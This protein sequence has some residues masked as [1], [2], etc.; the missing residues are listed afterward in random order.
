MSGINK[1]FGFQTGGPGGGDTNTNVA[2]ADLTLDDNHTTD[3][4][5][6]T[7]TIDSGTTN[8]AQFVGSDNT[9][10]IGGSTPYKMPTARAGKAGHAIQSTDAT[11]GTAFK[12]NGFALPF[13]MYAQGV[14]NLNYWYPEPMSNNKY[15]HLCRDSGL[16]DPGDWN[17]LTSTTLRACISGIPNDASV[18]SINAWVSC[19]DNAATGTPTITCEIWKVTPQ[20]GV[21]DQLTPVRLITA[22]SGETGDNNNKFYPLTSSTNPTATCSAGDL[23]M[24][25]FK[26]DELEE[27]NCDVWIT[28]ALWIYFK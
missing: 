22:T 2:N 26:I 5:S 1:G 25:V 20:E 4:G 23:I 17:I 27:V 19:L 6:D 9:L 3:V 24:P 11:T 16:S 10:Q 12:P 13:Q 7:L 14:D 21:A 15:P 8:I 18:Q 28:G